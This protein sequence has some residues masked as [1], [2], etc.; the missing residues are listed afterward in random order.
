MLNKECT[1]FLCLVCLVVEAAIFEKLPK[2][3]VKHHSLNVTDEPP[4]HDIVSENNDRIV[5]LER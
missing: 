2:Y 4:K 1:L 3:P 5:V